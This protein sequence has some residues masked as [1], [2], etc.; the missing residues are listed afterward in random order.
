MKRKRL[1]EEHAKHKPLRRT[2]K[3]KRQTEVDNLSNDLVELHSRRMKEYANKRL[4]SIENEKTIFSR[5]VE[6]NEDKKVYL[7][8][9]ESL[10]KE[11]YDS[12]IDT[13]ALQ[14]RCKCLK[15]RL[16]DN[17]G[18]IAKD[19]ETGRIRI[20]GEDRNEY[21]L[22]AI[23]FLNIHHILNAGIMEATKN[24]EVL[25]S[26]DDDY[27]Y[28]HQKLKDLRTE[29]RSNTHNY[30]TKFYPKLIREYDKQTFNKD[31]DPDVCV[32]CGGEVREVQNSMCVCINCSV[33]A[34]EG[35]STLDPTNNLNWEQLKDAPGRQY[36]YKRLNH[37]RELLRAKQGKSRA[38]IPINLYDEL[39]EEFRIGR[40]STAKINPQRVR[41]KLKKIGKSKYYE[42]CVAIA[43]YLNPA[44][45][46][47]CIDPS[48]EERLC[49]M[50]VQLEGPFEAI[51]HLVE[52]QRKNMISYPFAFFKLNELNGWDEYNR[53]CVLLN[54]VALINMQDRY[55][56][57]VMNILG[58]EII[59]PTV[60]VRKP[61]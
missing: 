55:W 45:R 54:S 23:P 42:H 11:K 31:P 30:T 37:F 24:F 8:L 50:F 58:W 56:N 7:R 26:S 51:K 43:A 9:L 27:H 35:F 28:L 36:T 32:H 12:N 29:F 52:R 47:I 10:N 40:I 46:P 53:D 6:W 16:L 18:D 20:S 3:R 25:N 41:V 21:L 5:C 1:T 49:L 39:R 48:H 57:M 2:M 60:D 33:V 38:S 13:S 14:I 61:Q 44:Y 17:K 4:Q 34:Q 19:E 15:Q 22:D 59:G